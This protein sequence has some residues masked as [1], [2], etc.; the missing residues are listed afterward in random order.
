MSKIKI[1]LTTANEQW[2]RGQ[3][4]P[5]SAVGEQWLSCTAIAIVIVYCTSENG[6]NMAIVCGDES[7]TEPVCHE[8]IDFH[9]FTFHCCFDK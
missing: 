1:K 3:R 2:N 4:L 6:N 5:N 7:L 8:T 9:N